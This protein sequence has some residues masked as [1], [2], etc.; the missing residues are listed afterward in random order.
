MDKLIESF[1]KQF[2]CRISYESIP[3]GL[4]NAHAFFIKMEDILLN[5]VWKESKF[6]CNVPSE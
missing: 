3:L 6:Y 5:E 1:T 4:G 2:N